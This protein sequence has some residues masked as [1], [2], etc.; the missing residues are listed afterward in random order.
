MPWNY[1]FWQFF[2]FAAPALAAGNVPQC[3]LAVEEV[4]RKASAR[5]A[6]AGRCWSRSIRWPASSPTPGSRRAS[7]PSGIVEEAVA[8]EFVAALTAA[9]AAL[10]VGDP[11]APDTAIGPMAR[12]GLRDTL[13]GQI[14]RTVAAGAG[15]KLGG[16]IP[17]GPGCYYPPTVLDHVRPGMDLPAR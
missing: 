12:A 16:E 9:A 10:K 6:C 13:H 5:R 4:V 14:R 11:T 1:P 15:L 2:R 17:D 7:T 3:A 8:D